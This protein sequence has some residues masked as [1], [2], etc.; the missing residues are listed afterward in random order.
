[1]GQSLSCQGG[2]SIGSLPVLANSEVVLS[3][4]SGFFGSDKRWRRLTATIC[5]LH[6]LVQQSLQHVEIILVPKDFCYV[7]CLYLGSIFLWYSRRFPSHYQICLLL[8]MLLLVDKPLFGMKFIL[9]SVLLVNWFCR[10]LTML[11]IAMGQIFFVRLWIWTQGLVSI[12]CALC[13]LLYHVVRLQL[14]RI[15]G[16]HMVLAAFSLCGWRIAQFLAVLVIS[17]SAL[18]ILTYKLFNAHSLHTCASIHQHWIW[19]TLMIHRVTL[20]ISFP[21]FLLCRGKVSTKSSTHDIGP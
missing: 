7:I 2:L 18:L 13:A 19:I 4:C 21:L 14:A 11:V 16:A 9:I 8:V 15:H 3:P 1:M 17:I 12:H 20:H 5:S 10:L 6:C